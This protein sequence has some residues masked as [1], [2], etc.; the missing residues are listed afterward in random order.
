MQHIGKNTLGGGERV[1]EHHDSSH[2]YFWKT[3]RIAYVRMHACMQAWPWVHVRRYTQVPRL[4]SAVKYLTTRKHTVSEAR[5]MLCCLSGEADETLQA[6]LLTCWFAQTDLQA[7]AHVTS[8]A[9]SAY[10]F[11]FGCLCQNCKADRK[12]WLP[13]AALGVDEVEAWHLTSF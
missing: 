10:L 5:F 2:V 12:L 4:A 13:K 3:T 6:M 7:P 9:Y 8:T 1:F 11:N